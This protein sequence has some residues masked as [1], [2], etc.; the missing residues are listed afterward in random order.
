MKNENSYTA[1]KYR[2]ETDTGRLIGVFESESEAKKCAN[3]S[4]Q[5]VILKHTRPANG[6]EGNYS[7][8]YRR[9]E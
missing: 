4:Y 6:C 8:Y 5:R 2:V 1:P 7:F 9:T 3:K